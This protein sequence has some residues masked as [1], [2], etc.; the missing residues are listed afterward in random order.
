MA[1]EFV[2]RKGLIVSGSTTMSGS[3]DVDGHISA[4]ALSGSFFGD[5]AGLTN[6]TAE[7]TGTTT[8]S[9]QFVSQSLVLITHNLNTTSPLVQ[10]YDEND[11]QII[12]TKIKIENNQQVLVEFPSEVSGKVV[13]AKGGHLF[14]ENPTGQYSQDFTNETSITVSH[15]LDT[16]SPFVQIYDAENEQVIPQKIKAIDS[17][18]ILVEFPTPTSGT[19][20]VAKGG[21]IIDAANLSYVAQSFTNTSLVSVTHNFGTDAPIV[22]VYDNNGLQIIPQEIRIIDENSLEVE[23]PVNTS[24]KVAISKGGHIIVGPEFSGSFRGEFISTENLN[25]LEDN[26]YSLGTTDKRWSDIFTGDLHLSNEGTS[27]NSIDGTTGNWTIQEG[28]D[29]LYIINNNTGK[30]FKIVLQEVL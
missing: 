13:I 25:P 29:N 9:E 7:I 8:F 15:L 19:I 20:V 24:G 11:E 21:H 18:S 27:G 23:F 16:I 14:L 17:S 12:P 2:A 26:I 28:S 5:G 4:S 1:N 3:L 22:Q 6:I 30:H 10:V